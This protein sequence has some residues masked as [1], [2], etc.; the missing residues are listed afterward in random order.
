MK[1][2]AYLFSSVSELEEII[3]NRPATTD[4]NLF[5]LLHTPIFDE[6][7]IYEV[8][9]LLESR[10][11]GCK[12]AGTSAPVVIYYGK[13]YTDKALIEFIETDSTEIQIE[14]FDQTVNPPKLLGAKSAEFLTRSDTKAMLAFFTNAYPFIPEYLDSFSAHCRVE[15][16]VAG[17]LVGDGASGSFVFTSKGIFR[18]TCL[19]ISFH[20]SGLYTYSKTFTGNET[21]HECYEMTETDDGY[22][23]EIDGYPAAEWLKSVLGVKSLH[24]ID[25]DPKSVMA[26]PLTRFPVEF[27]DTPGVSRLINYDPLT[28][29]IY[30]YN[31]RPPSGQLFRI[32]FINSDAIADDC[33]EACTDLSRKPIEL[34][35]C[36]TCIIRGIIV[37][38]CA[39]WELAP[40]IKAGVC[41]A[42]LMGEIGSVGKENPRN[43]S[44]N[45]ACT[46][47][48]IAENRR[49]V[50]INASS[51]RVRR[52]A[53][54]PFRET[55]N[56][57]LKF[58]N[59]SIA[60]KIGAMSAAMDKLEHDSEEDPANLRDRHTKRP[61]MNALMRD[62]KNQTDVRTDK[63][64]L[65]SVE[66]GDMAVAHFG[67]SVY[68]RIMLRTIRKFED[69]ID[70]HFPDIKLKIYSYNEDSFILTADSDADS[71]KFLTVMQELFIKYGT[72]TIANL[73][74]TAIHRFICLRNPE[75]NLIESL[76]I[77]AAKN[78]DTPDRFIVHEAGF[79]RADNMDDA[80][81]KTKLITEAI[82]NDG[83][84][85]YF[86]PIYDNRTGR[87]EKFEAL[88]RIRG[89]DGRIYFPG[90]FLE[91][92]KEYRLYLQLSEIMITKV[93][94]LF[95]DR[96]ET[97]SIN[98]SAY[99]INS[100]RIRNMIYSRLERMQSGSN[101]IFEVLE[102]EEFRDF[103]VLT[104]FIDKVR[105]YGVQIAIDD[106][107]A[108]FSNLLEIAKIAPN[109]IKIDGQIVREVIDSEMHRKIME[110]ILEMAKS[111][112]IELIAEYV[113]TAA[114]QKYAFE[115]GVRYSQ[116]FFFSTPIPYSDIDRFASKFNTAAQAV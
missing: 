1:S 49:Y 32:T 70:V 111:F 115:K 114:L 107:G 67:E 116:G 33:T 54:D 88:M 82:E 29:K 85:P 102:S 17:G 103:E 68:G 90:Q 74:Y 81:K 108:G 113:E 52:F 37:E 8:T 76:K 56:H 87:V 109:F 14:T 92:A 95:E 47:L 5:C 84:I 45:S 40:F 100:I 27:D 101:I 93:F 94:D 9:A 2:S 51:L 105:R 99:D 55:M 79:G 16:R 48:T 65:V 11:K 91:S 28:G 43:H 24:S 83:I 15:V 86:Q 60:E 66:R 63:I 26:N 53:E 12:I 3:N 50:S 22:I 34:M 13:L 7:E 58:Q 18:D 80:F 73:S 97:V 96:P 72:V 104:H 89:R 38:G 30:M 110:T 10:L 69:Y 112:D 106:F 41:G 62:L 23:N 61:N 44:L 21:I 77:I 6:P 36:Y 35:L 98:L 4:T 31:K 19:F 25:A 75:G 57:I 42:L 39:E 71:M 78:A 20:N 64:C 46:L 59:K